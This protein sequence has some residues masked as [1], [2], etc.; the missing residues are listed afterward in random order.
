MEVSKAPFEDESCLSERMERPKSPILTEKPSDIGSAI[1]KECQICSSNIGNKCINCD[2]YLCGFCYV[3]LKDK[4]ICP[5]CKKTLKLLNNQDSS[6]GE[7]DLPEMD[8]LYDSKLLALAMSYHQQF[9]WQFQ[10]NN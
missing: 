1:L 3:K 2:L 6:R 10:Q 8:R 7:I 9:D 4:S 5:H